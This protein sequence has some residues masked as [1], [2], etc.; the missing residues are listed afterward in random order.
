MRRRHGFTLIELLVVIAIIAVLV[1]ILLPAVQQAR[2]AARATQCKNNMKQLGLALHNYEGTFGLFPPSTTSGFNRGVWQYTLTSSERDPNLHLHSFASLIL[3]NLDQTAVANRIDYNVSALAAG[4]NREMAS[5]I[6]PAYRCPSYA[7]AMY[8]TDNL[9]ANNTM[10]FGAATPNTFAIR[11]YVTL[12]AKTV[13]GLSGQA[14]FPAEGVM[15]PGSRTRI[16]DIT[17]GTSNTLVLAE[18]KEEKA[19]VW[20]DGTS[21]CV[22][23]RFFN[24]SFPPPAGNYGG[25]SVSINYQP[26]YNG[27]G[28]VQNWGPSSNHT[29]GATHL[30]ADGS[31]QFLSEN[32]SADL[33]DA[34]VT[35]AN[36]GPETA[37][38]NKVEF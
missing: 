9:Y 37:A 4:A 29:G 7:G 18:T 2:E 26:Y 20:I 19:A 11:N 12:G 23:A 3:P 21:A 17:D 31:V 22:A 27:T 1:A 10:A 13:L 35:R 34:M 32:L 16:A 38:G 25:R 8:S 30:V 6:I 15:F 33:Y 24:P 5:K 36:G 14:S 28:I